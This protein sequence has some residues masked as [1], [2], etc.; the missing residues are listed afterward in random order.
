MKSENYNRTLV[1]GDIHGYYKHLE[2][3]L[4]IVNY[5]NN[6][7]RIIFLGDYIDR[8]D[9][10][11]KTIDF[12]IELS[13]ENTNVISLMGNHEDL[14][15]SNITEDGR[16]SK[17]IWMSNGS[18]STLKSFGLSL[19]GSLNL[20]DIKYIN[21]LSSL[22]Q[23]FIDE[24]LMM[25]FSHAGIDPTKPVHK[26]DLFDEYRGPMWIRSD[27]YNNKK[28]ADAYTFIFGHTPTYNM[29]EG[30]YDVL[31][32]DNK[33][34][35]DTGL[36]YGYKLTALEIIPGQRLKAYSVNREFAFNVEYQP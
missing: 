28:P 13:L 21:F 33:I 16:H 8:G 5:D 6:S 32:E 36:C 23:I 1:I 26:Q 15:L 27:F 12:V 29:R 7:D 18:D 11:K 34:G 25:V 10:P 4:E 9:N 3:L 30:L 14:M 17:S 35:I 19:Y 24:E 2:K 31:W 20:I 22:K